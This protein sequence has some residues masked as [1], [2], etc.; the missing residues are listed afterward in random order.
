MTRPTA[1]VRYDNQDR[2]VIVTGGSQGI[3][4]EIGARFADSGAHVFVADVKA[5]A[6][7]RRAG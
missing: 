3:G 7:S 2:V 4:A 5:P 6:E 1:S